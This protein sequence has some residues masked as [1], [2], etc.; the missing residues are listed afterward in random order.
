MQDMVAE[1]G[2]VIAQVVF[3]DGTTLAGNVI[4]NTLE[5]SYTEACPTVSI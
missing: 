4:T 1:D 2:A 3:E 5:P